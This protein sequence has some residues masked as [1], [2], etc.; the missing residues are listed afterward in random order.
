MNYNFYK[1]Q[2]SV[3]ALSN[4]DKVNKE[5]YKNISKETSF[6]ISE[7]SSESLKYPILDKKIISYTKEDFIKLTIE[8]DNQNKEIALLKSKLKKFIFELNMLK[9]KYTKEIS[10][11]S[12]KNNN[13]ESNYQKIKNEKD[14]YI[15]NIKL[16]QIKNNKL[17]N[18]ITILKSQIKTSMNNETKYVN[19]ISNLIQEINFIKEEQNKIINNDNIA[20]QNYQN[21]LKELNQ[22]IKE[23]NILEKELNNL[24][25]EDKEKNFDENVDQSLFDS[26]NFVNGKIKKIL[27]ESEEFQR[28]KIMQE[29]KLYNNIK[30]LIEEF[31]EIKKLVNNKDNIIRNTNIDKYIL[32]DYNKKLS[33]ENN[34][35]KQHINKLI[36]NIDLYVNQNHLAAKRIYQLENYINQKS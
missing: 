14:K 5:E 8:N 26:I 6:N 1:K 30:D 17:Q 22:K 15:N 31:N 13:L 27:T 16:L 4:K 10:K 21:E 2:L 11:L 18:D 28:G 12:N 23:K 3:E 25:I 35:L 19:Q 20:L 36:I 29:N 34:L 7:N 32:I 24:L 33:Y 9:D